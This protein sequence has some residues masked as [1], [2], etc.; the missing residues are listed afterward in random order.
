MKINARKRP[1]SP[2]S[3]PSTQDINAVLERVNSLPSEI[4]ITIYEFAYTNRYIKIRDVLSI[5]RRLLKQVPR[6]FLRSV[7]AK[8]YSQNI[9]TSST[10]LSRRQQLKDHHHPRIPKMHKLLINHGWS[11]Q[12][13]EPYDNAFFISRC[14]VD[15]S[16]N[17]RSRIQLDDW[18]AFSVESWLK[19]YQI[20]MCEAKDDMSVDEMFSAFVKEALEAL[21]PFNE[22]Y[23]FPETI[24]VNIV[25][26]EPE[27]RF[28]PPPPMSD[29]W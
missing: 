19:G 14:P 18:T 11:R 3:P 1:P 2:P 28:L 20:A 16:F 26:Y 12:R 15:G 7:R 9:F 13:A 17:V 8:F 24:G 10:S 22:D 6:P 29:Q 5:E 21:T 27:S 4:A 23:S 25:R